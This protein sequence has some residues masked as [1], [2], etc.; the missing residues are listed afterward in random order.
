MEKIRINYFRV[1]LVLLVFETINTFIVSRSKESKEIFL[2]LFIIMAI[3]LLLAYLYHRFSKTGQFLNATGIHWIQ[4]KTI[5]KKWSDISIQKKID[6]PLFK[7]IYLNMEN[8][9]R[10]FSILVC[11]LNEDNIVYLTKK[12]VPK[13]HELYSVVKEYATRRGLLL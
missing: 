8:E 1:F 11:W 5:S 12:Y 13:N 3:V 6:F 2:P 9:G 10:K 4:K 7:L